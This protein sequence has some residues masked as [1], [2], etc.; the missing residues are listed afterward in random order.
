MWAT[1][2]LFHGCTFRLLDLQCE[3]VLDDD[4]ATFLETQPTITKFV[5]NIRCRGVPYPLSPQTLPSL[6]ILTIR[7]F[8]HSASIDFH[9]EIL[10]GRPITHFRSSLYGHKNLPASI[11]ALHLTSM[12]MATLITIS[13]ELQSLKHLSVVDYDKLKVRCTSEMSATMF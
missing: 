6:G 4:L 1:V 12:D 2:P 9:P 5:W 7:G 11:Q 8:G 10:A 3:F 13:R